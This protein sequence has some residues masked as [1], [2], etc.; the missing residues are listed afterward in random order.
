MTEIATPDLTEATLDGGGVFDVLMQ[1]TKAHLQ[2]EYAKGRIKGSDYSEV[3]LGALTVVMQQAITFLLEKDRAAAQTTLILEQVNTERAQQAYL[4]AQTA[5]EEASTGLT[6]EQTRNAVKEGEVLD[7]QVC[8]LE[9]EYDVLMETK[10][11]VLAEAG[12]LI[13]KKVTEKAQVTGA[14]VDV[15]SVIGR[16]KE[17]Y[18]AQAA[19]FQRDAEQKAAK[20]LAD[21]WNVRRTTDDGVPADNTNMLGDAQIGRAINRLLQG[22]SA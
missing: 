7:R 6:E 11:K 21:T 17:L 1:A 9:A 13:Q 2:E 18:S 22:I 5:G 19:G 16:Q 8:K 20:I 10:A 3:Y 4:V 12:L 14:G 15:D